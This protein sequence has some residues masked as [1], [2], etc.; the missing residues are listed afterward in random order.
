[1]T[2]AEEDSQMNLNKRKGI[3]AEKRE[4]KAE[5]DEAQ[6]YQALR[7][8]L[9]QKNLQLYLVQL[10][11]AEHTRE[12]AKKELAKLQEE[13]GSVSANKRQME[14]SIGIKVNDLKK[15]QREVRKLEQK[16]QEAERHVTDQRPKFMKIKQEMAHVKNKL[17]TATKFHQTAKKSAE[18]H[19]KIVAQ[20][21]EKKK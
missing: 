7:D 6:R 5:K 9:S 8:D 10:F 14:E 18:E 20:C 2:K 19:E 16:V 11:F 13:V 1:M 21:E 15:H 12:E 4:A 3:V 17:E